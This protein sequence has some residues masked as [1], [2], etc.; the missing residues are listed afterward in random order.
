MGEPTDN[1]TG[2]VVAA[3]LYERGA[4]SLSDAVEIS[5]LSAARFSEIINSVERF[6]P[7]TVLAATGRGIV[8]PP[9]FKLSVLMPVYNEART[10]KEIIER[11]REVNLN[12]EIIVVDDGSSDGTVAVLKS[13]IE[14]K[15]P[16]VRVFYSPR[17][18]GKGAAVR[19]AIKEATG[20]VCVVQDAD[21]EYDP[22]EYFQ[23]LEPIIDGRA[24]A[25]FGTRFM[26]G[27]PHRVHLFWH[28]VGNQFLTTIS[29]AFSNLNLTDMET[30]YKLM[31][32]ELAQSLPLRANGFDIEPELTL[33]LAKAGARIYE[34]PISYSGRSYAEGK[35]IN[36]KDG[37]KALYSI[38]RYRFSD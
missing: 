23:L 20:D 21:L 16:D 19:R 35:K 3:I 27:G 18:Q 34:V 13:E 31:R 25:V 28:Y 37:F 9:E 5:G 33:K 6:S 8:I 7:N 32:T 29:N 10:I 24:D 36:W 2:P 12:K 4:V 17:N 1:G 15:V 30:C 14:G 11:V 26:G 22:Q 38:F